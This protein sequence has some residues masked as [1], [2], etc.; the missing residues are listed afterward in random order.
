MANR[1]FSLISIL[2]I[3]TLFVSLASIS[4]ASAFYSPSRKRP[5]V[6]RCLKVWWSFL[7]DY[8]WNFRWSSLFGY[9]GS[10]SEVVA[11]LC[12]NFVKI[13]R[14]ESMFR[15]ANFRV[16]WT[17]GMLSDLFALRMVEGVLKYFLMTTDYSDNLLP[18]L[19]SFFS[20]H[21]FFIQFALYSFSLHWFISFI[22]VAFYLA[23][24][25]RFSFKRSSS[26]SQ[27]WQRFFMSK[28]SSF[29]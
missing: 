1:F 14:V 3:Y 23:F 25:F 8:R 15:W 20:L 21:C 2:S 6:W 26:S 10:G 4:L 28:V 18:D 24:W 17:M 29:W 11:R 16:V 19:N 27:W 22:V 13:S 12:W 9:I 7:M 5:V